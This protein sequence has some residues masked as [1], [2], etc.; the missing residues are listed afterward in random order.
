MLAIL[1]GLEGHRIGPFTAESL[2]KPLDLA[3]GAGCVGLGTDVMDTKSVAVL[4]KATRDVG[5]T[6]FRHFLTA[7]YTWL[8]N[9]ATTELRNP[10]AVAC[11]YEFAEKPVRL[12]EI[13]QLPT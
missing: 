6:A 12:C 10:I 1:R 7:P 9:Q 3:V 5:G 4:G 2:D 11:C 13:G 8:L